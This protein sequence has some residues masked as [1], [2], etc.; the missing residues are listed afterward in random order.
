MAGPMEAR[1]NDRVDEP[2]TRQTPEHLPVGHTADVWGLSMAQGGLLVHRGGSRERPGAPEDPLAL[3]R[4]CES[5]AAIRRAT[6]A[7]STSDLD[8]AWITTTWTTLDQL[9]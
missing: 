8:L 6:R 4:V 9:T 3:D 7:P 5:D 2:G 1:S